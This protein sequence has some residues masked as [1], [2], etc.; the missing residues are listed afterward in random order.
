VYDTAKDAARRAICADEPEVSLDLAQ[1]QVI[2][3]RRMSMLEIEHQGVQHIAPDEYQL[4]E[5][6]DPADLGKG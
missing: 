2:R 3:P 5:I 4:I 1:P 6:L